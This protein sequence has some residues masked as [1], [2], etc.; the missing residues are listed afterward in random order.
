MRVVVR[1]SPGARAP[2]VGGRYG[3]GE[4]PAL[5]VRVRERPVDGK[6]N[7]AVVAAVAQA[8]GVPRREVRLVSG[9]RSQTKLLEVRGADPQRLTVLLGAAGG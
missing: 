1:V 3:D 2:G 8:F 5:I 9:Q 4:P 7:A 6:A